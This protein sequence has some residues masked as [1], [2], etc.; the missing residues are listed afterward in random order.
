MENNKLLIGVQFT[1]WDDMSPEIQ[2]R[3]HLLIELYVLRDITFGQLMDGLRFGLNK[4][5]ATG[6]SEEQRC[7]YE[8]CA[9]IYEKYALRTETDKDGTPF[10]SNLTLTCYYYKNPDKRTGIGYENRLMRFYPTDLETPLFKLGFITSSRLIIDSGTD[11]FDLPPSAGGPIGEFDTK[12]ITASFNPESSPKIRFPEYHISSRQMECRDTEPVT[13]I[14]PENPPQPHFRDLLDTLLPPLISMS[15]LFAARLFMNASVRMALLSGILG[16]SAACVSLLHWFRQGK[17]INLQRERWKIRYTEYINDLIETIRKRQED[18]ADKLNRLYPDMLSLIQANRGIYTMN[19]NLYSRSPQDE[20]FLTFRLGRSPHVESG[21]PIQGEAREAIFSEAFFSIRT[22][23]TK[24]TVSLYL[25]GEQWRIGTRRKGETPQKQENISF[26]PAEIAKR[27]RYLKDAPLL[28]SLRNKGALGVLDCEIGLE[29]GESY[30]DQGSRAGYLVQRMIFEL[31][32]YHSPDN[33]QFVLFFPPA[34]SMEEIDVRIAQYKFM[35]HF[36]GLFSDRAQFV[37]DKVSAQLTFSGLLNIATSRREDKNGSN[38]PHIVLIL[39]DEYNLREHAFAELLPKP[40]EPGKAFENTLGMTFVYVTSCPEY[41][42]PYCDDVISF[43]SSKK[44]EEGDAFPI[45]LVPRQ[46]SGLRQDFRFPDSEDYQENSANG[47]VYPVWKKGESAGLYVDFFQDICEA[48]Q[49]FSS[50]YYASVAQDGKVPSVVSVY[51]LLKGRGANLNGEIS[52]CWGLWNP[53]DRTDITKSL[54]VPIGLSDETT[55]TYLDLHEKCDGPHMLV[56]GTTGSG[57]TETIISYLLGLCVRFRPD[58]LNLLL[59]DMKGGGFIKRIGTLPHIV[60]NVTDVDGDENGSGV[61]YMLGRFLSALTAEI[62]RRKILFNKLRVDNIDAYIRVCRTR[63]SIRDHIANKQFSWKEEEEVLRIA[64]KEPLSHIILVVDEFTEL[65][66]F[67]RKNDDIDFIEQITSIARIG[68]SLGLHIILI[69]QNIENAITEDIRVNSNARLCMRVATRQASKEMIGTELAASPS[70]PGNGRAYLL[71]GT[72]SKFEYFQ[73]GYSGA[74]AHEQNTPVEITLASKLGQYRS[75]YKS[76][77]DNNDLISEEKNRKD[78]ET[79]LDIILRAVRGVYRSHCVTERTWDADEILEPHI[80]FRPPL[81]RRILYRAPVGAGQNPEILDLESSEREESARRFSLERDEIRQAPYRLA[82]GVY[83]APQTQRQP[84]WELPYLYSNIAVFGAPGSGKTSFLKTLLLRLHELPPE[85]PEESIYIIDFSGNIGNYGNFPLVCACFNDSNE[86][87]VKRIFHTIDS[88][89]TENTERLG[90]NYQQAVRDMADGKRLDCPPH[91][92]LIIENL[93][94]FL[95]DVRY[96]LYV[97]ALRRLCR[98]GLS[99]GLTVVFTA[100]DTVGTSRLMGSFG[101]KI[102]FQMPAES[103]YEIFGA[104]TPTP[105]RLPGRGV[106]NMEDGIYE[107]QC[108][109]PATEAEESRIV[110]EWNAKAARHPNP[111]RLPA[112][113]K[114][115][116]RKDFALLRVPDDAREMG[117]QIPIGLDYQYHRPVYVNITQDRCLAIYGADEGGTSGLLQGRMPNLIRLLVSAIRRMRPE[118]RFVLLDDGGERLR[119]TLPDEIFGDSEK[120]LL[121]DIDAFSDYCFHYGYIKVQET[122]EAKKRISERQY[123]FVD[124]SK[125]EY[126][127]FILQNRML[128]HQRKWWTPNYP[129]SFS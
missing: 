22:I 65:K 96:E 82:M 10:F 60:G 89:L 83:D 86:E 8:K 108:F 73:S 113:P 40:P 29:A 126:T 112:F 61:E 71:V 78:T 20:D 23:G 15:F 37:F 111:Y 121:H 9:E 4:L 110:A 70:M 25:N 122:Q 12:Y 117:K 21:F 3:K 105:M 120:V 98:D 57:K 106:I 80:I 13:I 30:G 19:R 84:L 54:R 119:H 124:M 35:P 33:L 1:L 2:D 38:L 75:F 72:G 87:D 67:S 74:S 109:L 90:Q 64:R 43:G 51:E 93:N 63:E 68:R 34:H 58:E 94:A 102:T 41:L 31:C 85:A 114:I 7:L 62:K 6:S 88:R 16:V 39:Y 28:Y 100:S 115:L 17:K 92:T 127:A 59:V 66:Q 53:D 18:D 47:R 49:F 125:P 14:P 107:F 46:D 81:P 55:V 48:Y 42:P 123:S 99:K 44:A 26:L 129:M 11:L 95:S 77:T 76:D 91:M 104:R 27:Y 50:I 32:Y 97:D 118:C 52:S 128:Y 69:S 103:C 56:A 116:T 45:R 36:H 5:K 24:D 101:Q 79:Q